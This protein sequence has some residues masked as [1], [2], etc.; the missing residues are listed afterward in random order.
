MLGPVTSSRRASPRSRSTS[1]GTQRPAGSRVSSTGW[2]PSRMSRTSP[3]S[4]SGRIQPGPPRLTAEA[5]EAAQ[6]VDAGQGAG[7]RAQRLAVAR[8]QLA[9]LEEQL[10]LER[11]GL[12]VGLQDGGLQLL[13]LGRDVAL[14]AG[15]RLLAGVVG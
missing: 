13:E 8:G 11:A 7:Q 1:L 14:G 5:R 10:G 6:H 15:Q 9:Q 3:A 2:R 12:L 4:T